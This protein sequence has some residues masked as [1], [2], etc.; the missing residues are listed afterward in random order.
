[1]SDSSDASSKPSVPPDGSSDPS[2]E[3][4]VPPD[5][6]NPSRFRRALV[7]AGI[8]LLVTAFVAAL[9]AAGWGLYISERTDR[10]R[11][12]M[13]GE[14]PTAAGLDLYV[15]AQRV[16]TDNRQLVLSVLPVPKGS[17]AGPGHKLAQDMQIRT[18]SLAVQ[19]I[20]LAKGAVPAPQQIPVPL[21]G[22]AVSDYPRDH[23]WA[24]IYWIAMTSDGA[25]VDARMIFNGADPFFTVRPVLDVGTVL[26]LSIGV[27]ALDVEISRSHSTLALAGFLALAMWT[28]ALAVLSGAVVL[29]RQRQRIVWP[30]MG[31]MAATLF[32]IVGLRSAAPGSPPI[33]SLLDYTAFFWS[34]AIITVS[35]ACVTVSGVRAEGRLSTRT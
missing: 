25:F 35:V 15:T 33:G 29:V 12:T 31:W 21:N 9:V 4:F 26:A 22:G 32:A 6:T 30:A 2:P 20:H 27:A 16:D 8:A 34:E 7:P 1:M 5:G 14:E 10:Q 23:Y 11:Q 28:L 3:Q 24:G 17:L 19:S 13:V 18:S